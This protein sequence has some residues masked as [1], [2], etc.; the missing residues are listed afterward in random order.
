MSVAVVSVSQH[1]NAQILSEII[2]ALDKLLMRG[3]VM[4]MLQRNFGSLDGWMDEGSMGGWNDG[5][6]F[7]SKVPTKDFS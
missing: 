7:F 6:P 3:K 2:Y 1:L 4:L 5:F